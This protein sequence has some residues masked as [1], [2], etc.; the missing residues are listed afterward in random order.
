[1][2]YNPGFI[3]GGNHL[4]HD[5]HPSRSIGYYLEAL[6]ALAPFAKT[7]LRI[8]L[9][10]VVNDDQDTSVSAYIIG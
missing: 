8:N 2:R 1:M 3:I 5:C 7:P 6:V 9:R 4:E 10:G